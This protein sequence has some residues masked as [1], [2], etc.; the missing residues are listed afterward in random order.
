MNLS[1]ATAGKL[2]AL[3]ALLAT[4]KR[5]V[6]LL[7]GGVDSSL[8][9]RAAADILGPG[10]L[11]LTFTGPHCPAEEAAAA[12]ALA[13][14]LGLRHR[15]ETFDPFL[16]PDFRRNTARRCYACKQALYRRSWE[17]AR[18]E[19]AEAVLDGA[20]A[21]DAAAERPGLAAAAAL[22]IRSPL[23][24][25]GFLKDDIRELA[26]FWDLPA[27]NRP[28]QSCLATRF[29]VNTLLTPQDLRHVDQI[30]GLLRR[31]G[32]GPVRLRVH[33]DLVR[34]EIP[35]QQW[36]RLLASP[37]L[38]ELQK[39]VTDQGWRYLTL[40]LRGYQSGSMNAPPAEAS[41]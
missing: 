28:A 33:G 16:L 6:I 40:D 30:E 35:P 34:L 31:Q 1:P 10:V 22:A 5:V 32:F 24:E 21:A 18:Q 29:P 19:G 12:S 37:A 39:L 11:A 26:R 38:A 13:R 8:L 3:Q 41:V 7:S 25:T 9:A 17:I 27:W 36:P 20:T 2:A 23:R 4:W 14:A 15:L